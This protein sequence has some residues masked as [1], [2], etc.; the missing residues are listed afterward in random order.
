MG[1]LA[2]ICTTSK[3]VFNVALA[4]P[5][6]YV[7][8]ALA[9]AMSA[10]LNASLLYFKLHQLGVYRVSSATLFFVAKVLVACSGMVITII[11]L[12]SDVEFWVSMSTWDKSLKLAQLILCG[13]AVF[14]VILVILGVRPSSFASS[15]VPSGDKD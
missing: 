14:A 2:N 1:N 15:Q 3:G 5:Y 12:N 9:T 4:I 10:T 7:G 8:L 11:A 6:G 13:F